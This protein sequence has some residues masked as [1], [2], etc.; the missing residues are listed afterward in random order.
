MLAKEVTVGKLTP[1]MVLVPVVALPVRLTFK[2]LVVTDPE[3]ELLV[4]ERLAKLSLLE[5]VVN[6][7]ASLPDDKVKLPDVMTSLP[8]VK[9]K[10]LPEARV[11]S[12]LIETS[13]EEVLNVPLDPEASKLPL[14]WV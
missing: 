1:L 7:S 12:P 5:L 13:P 3:P 4:K 14:D 10:F 8:E 6:E 2:A 11:V 9:V